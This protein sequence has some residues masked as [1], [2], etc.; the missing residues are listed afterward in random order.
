MWKDPIV[1]EVREARD[2][3]ARRF[4]WDL[5]ALVEYLREKAREEAAE[6]ARP[7]GASR[8][9]PDRAVPVRPGQP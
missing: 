1:E 3:V 2:R 6:V 5:T 9:K 4:G 7:G 8:K